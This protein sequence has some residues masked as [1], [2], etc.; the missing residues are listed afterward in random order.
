MIKNEGL[1][2]KIEAQ[3]LQLLSL[4]KANMELTMGSKELQKKVVKLEAT[5]DVFKQDPNLQKIDLN[6]EQQEFMKKR[7]DAKTS[8]E[9][10]VLRLLIHLIVDDKAGKGDVTDHVMTE[11]TTLHKGL[12]EAYKKCNYASGELSKFKIDVSKDE[13][14]KQ[15]INCHQS[16]HPRLNTDTSCNYHPGKIKFYSCK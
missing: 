12:A 8:I 3:N 11:I 5:V 6:P 16:Y 7:A 9:Q 1:E 15:C 14:E 13:A 2:K 4:Q 10:E